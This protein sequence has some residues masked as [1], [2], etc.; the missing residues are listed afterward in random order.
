[1]HLL[2][3][4]ATSSLKIFE[5]KSIDNGYML[6][7]KQ[8]L[9]SRGQLEFMNEVSTYITETYTYRLDFDIDLQ[10]IWEQEQKIFN[11]GSVLI[12]LK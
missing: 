12:Y 6:L 10:A 3:M 2:N 11:N 1:M 8:E 4:P 9:E 7:R 5:S